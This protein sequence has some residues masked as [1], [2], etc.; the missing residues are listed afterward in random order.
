MVDP[1]TVLSTAGESITDKTASVIAVLQPTTA[2]INEYGNGVK[3]ASKDRERFIDELL[4]LQ[5]VLNSV[6]EAVEDASSMLLNAP[7]GLPHYHTEVESLKAKL[8]TLNGHSDRLQELIW[9]LKEG[10]IEKMPEYLK[11]FQQLLSMSAT[12]NTVHFASQDPCAQFCTYPDHL[13][14]GVSVEISTD[15]KHMRGSVARHREPFQPF[16]AGPWFG[17][18]GPLAKFLVF[19]MLDPCRAPVDHTSHQQK[20]RIACSII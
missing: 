14:R 11:N 1:L 13:D 17:L 12:L 6:H 18:G 15:V 3:H 8:E 9:P 10:D 16:S 4:M 19:P 2:T 5:Q 20:N 7:E